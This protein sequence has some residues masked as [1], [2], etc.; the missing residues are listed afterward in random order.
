[1]DSKLDFHQLHWQ[2]PR[3]F[4][5]KAVAARLTAVASGFARPELTAAASDTAA[6]LHGIAAI[7]RSA[8]QSVCAHS[9]SK[10][11]ALA[12]GLVVKRRKSCRLKVG[13]AL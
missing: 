11:F 3:H 2:Q 10:W 4:T 12:L 13:S 7:A 1:M 9:G 8:A 6:R 5:I